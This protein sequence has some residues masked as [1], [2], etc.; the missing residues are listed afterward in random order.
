MFIVN[1]RPKKE[2]FVKTEVDRTIY[3]G[4]FGGSFTWHPDD[5]VVRFAR[6]QAQL[7]PGAG[8]GM[9]ETGGTTAIEDGLDLGVEIHLFRAGKGGQQGG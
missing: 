9:A 5:T 2:T 7:L 1:S 8:A 4:R 6:L 3:D